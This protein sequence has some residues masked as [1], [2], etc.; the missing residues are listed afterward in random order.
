MCNGFTELNL[1]LFWM[2][3]SS[4][5]SL[6]L[7]VLGD[8][9]RTLFR[10]LWQRYLHLRY[11]PKQHYKILSHQNFQLQL[12]IQCLLNV[13]TKSFFLR[14]YFVI[15]SEHVV[16]FVK[17]SFVKNSLTNFQNVLF[18]TIP[19]WV[20]FLK[21]VFMHFLGRGTI[22]SFDFCKDVHSQALAF[23]INYSL[24]CSWCK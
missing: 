22:Y 5:F 24:T 9:H 6:I 20:T 1:K 17:T 11:F 3:V 13:S 14:H 4:V 18:V 23:S 2:E 16:L 8:F 10:D 7:A 21:N 19:L 12:H 15:L